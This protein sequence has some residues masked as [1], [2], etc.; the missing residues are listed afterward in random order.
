M[1][2]SKFISDCGIA[3]RRKAEDI[4][5]SGRIKVNNNVVLDPSVDID[6]KKDAVLLDDVRI[7]ED[8]KFV[9]IALNKPVQYISDL[10]DD[11]R[12]M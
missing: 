8:I 9:Y 7:K 3:S 11:K 1:R 12:R 2:L 6:Y 4:I 10:K 5:R